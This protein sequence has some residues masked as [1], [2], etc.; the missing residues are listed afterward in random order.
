MTL[1]IAHRG[2]SGYRPEMTIPSYELALEQGADGLEIDVRLTKDLELIG[3]HDR[4]TQRVANNNLNVSNSTLNEL[5]A[6]KV[7]KD[8]F[9][10]SIISMKEFFELAIDSNKELTL[11]LE[12]KH[13]T[14]FHG[15]LENKLNELL[16]YFGLEKNLH[17]NIKIVLMS[18]NPFAVKRFSKLNPLIERV[19]L[20]EHNYPFLQFYPNPGNP[21]NIGP[22]I[23][24]LHKKPNLI[25]YFQ[26]RGKKI[27]VW[28][29]NTEEDMKFCLEHKIDAIIT[30]YPDIA[31][32]VRKEFTGS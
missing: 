12:T 8:G 13:P 2:A 20:K 23:E 32:K 14:K 17:K 10:S 16:T 21:S 7:T 28:T 19:Q 18:F 25:D 31:L 5:K 22:G 15:L 24:L 4:T 3:F 6:L 30:N 1:V 11:C 29:V 26:K 27:F 9:K